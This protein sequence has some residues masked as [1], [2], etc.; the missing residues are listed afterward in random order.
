MRR[1]LDKTYLWSGYIAAFCLASIAV[2]IILQV[3]GRFLGWVVDSTEVAGFLL[4]A[5][6]F[7]ALA[8]TFRSGSHVRVTLLINRLTGGRRR[9]TETFCCGAAAFMVCYLAY[10]SVL[11]VLRSYRFG[12]ISPGLVAM[13]F[14]IPQSAMAVGLILLAVALIDEMIAVWRGATPS[15]TAN[16]DVALD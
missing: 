15:Y 14:W 16:E 5:S 7:F 6:S 9:I 12:D 1:L 13:P 2:S 8:H 11:L 3:V 10:H 4:A